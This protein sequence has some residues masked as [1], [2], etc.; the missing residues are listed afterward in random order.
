MF[1][2]E[3][4]RNWT[5]CKSRRQKRTSKLLKSVLRPQVAELRAKRWYVNIHTAQFTGEIRG[6]IKNID[7]AFDIDSD[8]RTFMFIV[9]IIILFTFS[10]A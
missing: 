3:F 6:E 8:G 5:N 2:K 9:R 4:S 10:A 1:C 7:T